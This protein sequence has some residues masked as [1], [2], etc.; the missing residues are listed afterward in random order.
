MSASVRRSGWCGFSFL[1]SVPFLMPIASARSSRRRARSWRI[2]LSSVRAVPLSSGCRVWRDISVTPSVWET[3]ETELLH[4]GRWIVAHCSSPAGLMPGDLAPGS[5]ERGFPACSTEARP[6]QHLSALHQGA[7]LV[8]LRHIIRLLMMVVSDFSVGGYAGFGVAMPS[9]GTSRRARRTSSVPT[10][11]RLAIIAFVLAPL[12]S[13]QSSPT[14]PVAGQAPTSGLVHLW[15]GDGTTADSVGGATGSLRNGAS[16]AAGKV[17]QAFNLDGADDWVDLGTQAGTFGTSDFTIA[18]WV[19]FRSLAGE[20][21]IIEKYI[22]TFNSGTRK[23]WTLTKLS[24]GT[25][26]WEGMGFVPT[27]EPSS[28]NHITLTRSGSTYTIYWNGVSRR[29]GQ[30]SS[31]NNPEVNDTTTTLKLGHRGGPSDTPG[32]TDNRGFFLNG[33]LDDVRIYNR[34]LSQAEIV[35]LMPRTLAFALQPVSG[36][37][38]QPF[39]I[40]PTVQLRAADGS[41]VAGDNSTTITLS[42]GSGPAG[43][44]SCTG[45]LTTTMVGG[46]AMFTGCRF[47]QP[48][49]YTLRAAGGVFDAVESQ[50]IVVSR[51]DGLVHHWTGDATAVD[52]VGGITGILRGGTSYGP[53]KFRQ[54]FKLDG[55]DDWIELGNQPSDIARSDFTISI[56]VNYNDLANEQVIIERYIESGN[57][58][59]W[60][61]T[62]HIDS[63]PPLRPWSWSQSCER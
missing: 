41:M 8:S 45:G 52:E 26:I 62:K 43:S 37:V 29:T 9:W 47:D 30:Q 31:P 53:G 15:T 23:G 36:I 54:A 58:Q 5:K 50:P 24:D 61:L 17:A 21:V 20:Q 18:L 42:K 33:F 48:G 10:P 11:L 60:S 25:V 22:E 39:M 2:R 19:N 55:L 59:S 63:P 3:K 40:Q 4:C 38:N 57:A 49:T 46:S 32:S 7:R 16:F 56:W 28:W 34:A 44:L 51:A 1:E 13:A 12:L 14:P 27:I 35:S 6:H